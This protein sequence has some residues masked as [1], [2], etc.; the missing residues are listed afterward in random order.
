MDKEHPLRI[1]W[2]TLLVV[3][4]MV[5]HYTGGQREP[6]SPGGPIFI[7][8]P[9]DRVDFSN[10]T[11]AT[12]ECSVHGQPPPAVRWAHAD[13]SAVDDMEGIR[14]V[15]ANG[16]L[17]FMPFRAELYRQDI[18]AG[19]YL[20]LA[21]S[22]LGVI[23]SRPVYVRAVVQQYYEV[24]VYDEFVI[25]GNIAVLKCHIPP[26]VR[27]HVQVTS[28]IRN[29]NVHIR[30]AVSSSGSRFAML[31]T[32]E[33]YVYEVSIEDSMDTFR[34]QTMNRLTQEVKLS[35]PG[36]IIVSD[37]KSSIPPRIIHS[38]AMV[39]VMKGEVA[40]LPCVAQGLPVPNHAWYRLRGSEQQMIKETERTEIK[41][42]LLL[43]RNSQITDAGVFVCKASNLLGE[44][45]YE[46]ILSVR[47][48]LSVFVEPQEV[49]AD[50]GQQV[51][52]S[53]V[54]SGHPITSMEWLKDGQMLLSGKSVHENELTIKA[55]D[56]SKRGMYQCVISNDESAAQ[57]TA[58]LRLG[59]IPPEVGG[60]F[61]KMPVNPGASVELQCVVKGSPIP[62][63]TWYLDEAILTV[64]KTMASSGF[65]DDVGNFVSVLKISPVQIQDSGH[66]KCVATNDA[67]E[68]EYSKRIDVIGAISI[69]K[70]S[71]IA[72]TRGK[73]LKIPCPVVG[74]PI[75]SVSWKKD[76][77]FLPSHQRQKVFSNG[78]LLIQKLSKTMDEGTYTCVAK[79][80]DGKVVHQNCILRIAVP[81][82]I[83]SNSFP[84][85]HSLHL[86]TRARLQCV[87]TE[88]DL[89]LTIRWL[90]DNRA[91]SKDLPVIIRK[92]DDFA[93]VLTIVN[94]TTAHQGNYTCIANNNAASV[95]ITTQIVIE[96][97]PYWLEQP[98]DV[99]AVHY[100]DVILNCSAH[101][102]PAPTIVWKKSDFST[103]L[104]K[105]L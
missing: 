85:H 58:E 45:K 68:A 54:A 5:A 26:F 102:S 67:G 72:A 70:M 4:G 8:E 89:P 75:L 3:V 25:V 97:P 56:G 96:V 32:G 16:S 21:S 59:A 95:N 69:R 100:S 92:E 82:V 57:G 103:S 40:E 50:V 14:H 7:A 64:K 65:S 91:F 78:T 28:W 77:N 98:N 79:G 37:P 36:R 51:S 71:D 66:Y 18:H 101:G 29:H 90:K 6:L 27:E 20:C 9:P 84:T 86:G 42:G 44:E 34:C 74:Y 60:K 61:P 43:I 19:R 39:S 52:F 12:L 53:C 24:Q 10:T 11:G 93:S 62:L 99:S 33:L 46:T 1:L 63:I 81:P 76:G 23:R 30:S 15:L 83:D 73:K 105:F 88:G 47:E 17:V 31:S 41:H 49:T 2:L 22:P 94:I 80:E 55:V 35:A 48:P 13:G 87:L 38:Y 104:L